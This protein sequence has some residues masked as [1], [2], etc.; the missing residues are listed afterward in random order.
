MQYDDHLQ[1]IML[2]LSLLLLDLDPLH[3]YS[4]QTKLPNLSV[5]LSFICS[6]QSKYRRMQL[7]EINQS[8]HC[9]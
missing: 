4:N 5:Y 7:T 6:Y 1:P 3:D 2:R 8:L 9:K